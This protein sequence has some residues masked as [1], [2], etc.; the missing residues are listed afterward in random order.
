MSG[1]A[2]VREAVRVILLDGE[3]RVL[4]FRAAM[5]PR[6]D[7]RGPRTIW[8]APGG[9]KD[10]GETDEETAA[11]ELWEETGIRAPLGPMVWT[12]SYTFPW[13]GRLVEQRERFFVARTSIT[14]VERANWTAEERAFLA[15]HRWWAV[16]EIAA[17]RDEVFVPRSMAQHLV[18]LIRG[19][20]PAAPFDVGV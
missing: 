13:N 10:P 20:W 6:P 9:G 12:R 16:D 4:L 1:V 15:E 5:P 19:E 17:A 11:R 3:G 14:A 8:I 18:P 2:V 7:G